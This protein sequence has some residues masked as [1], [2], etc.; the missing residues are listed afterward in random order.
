MVP[1]LPGHKDT[2]WS[3]WSPGH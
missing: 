1:G 2:A 3:S